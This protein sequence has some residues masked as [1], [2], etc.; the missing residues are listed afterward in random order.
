M[1]VSKEELEQLLTRINEQNA[2]LGKKPL[3]GPKEVLKLLKKTR[4]IVVAPADERCYGGVRFD[5]KKEL[6]R[7]LELVELQRAGVVLFIIRQPRFDLP[8]GTKYT[9]DFLV[10]YKDRAREWEGD[11]RIVEDVKG[12][13]TPE[14]KRA[15]R[16]VEGM[17]PVVIVEPGKTEKGK[18]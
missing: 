18:K 14:F 11:R 15:K 12:W 2:R 17:Y 4:R 13:E 8:G 3:K 1:S 10:F 16:Q 5:S 6:A 9:A 7:F